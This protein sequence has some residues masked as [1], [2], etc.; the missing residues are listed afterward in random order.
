MGAVQLP[1]AL[2]TEPSF[3][4][5]VA[6][7]SFAT[8]R[9]IA[10]DRMGQHFNTGPWVGRTLLRPIVEIALLMVRF[11]YHLD[12]SAASPADMVANTKV[13]VLLIHGEVDRNI[14]V[15][16][17]RLIK[18]RIRKLNCGRSL[19]QTIAALFRLRRRVSK[20]GSGLVPRNS[21]QIHH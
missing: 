13:P 21:A 6:E 16:H 2:E 14:P 18:A 15:R 19:A 11:R 1:Q 4:A 10:Y 3:C 9:E 12:L 8:F 7:S 5:V 20:K 17:S